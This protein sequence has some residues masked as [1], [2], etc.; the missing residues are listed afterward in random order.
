[1]KVVTWQIP[2]L[3]ALMKNVFMTNQAEN[4]TGKRKNDPPK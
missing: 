3:T 1:M 2:A 4:V